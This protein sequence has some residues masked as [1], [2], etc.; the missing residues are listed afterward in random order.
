MTSPSTPGDRGGAERLERVGWTPSRD[1]PER[2]ARVL[3]PRALNFSHWGISVG[4][5]VKTW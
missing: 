5:P 3:S 4:A 2:I 1:F